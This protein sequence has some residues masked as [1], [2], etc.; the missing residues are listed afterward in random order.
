MFGLASVAIAPLAS[1]QTTQNSSGRRQ[2]KACVLVSGNKTAGLSPPIKRNFT[3]HLW[4]VMD[5]REDV[6]PGG[7]EFVNPLAPSTITGEIYKRWQTRGGVI[8]PA[9]RAMTPESFIFQIGAQ[10]TKNMAPYW[11][12]DLDTI[13][14]EDLRQ[15]DI[16][17][18]SLNRGITFGF[19]SEIRE[20]L[21]RF[22]DGGGT[23]WLESGDKTV[24]IDIN[25]PFIFPVDFNGGET[26]GF[27]PTIA[28]QRHPILQTPFSISQFEAAGIGARAGSHAAHRDGNDNKFLA[29]PH[30]LYP[31]LWSGRGGNATPYVSAGDY[32]AG[33]VV[34]SSAGIAIGVTSGVGAGVTGVE[35]YNTNVLSGSSLNGSAPADLKI[36]YNIVSFGSNASTA[37]SNAR[38]T[39]ATPDKVGG[40]LGTKWATV[41]I[42]ANEAGGTGAVVSKGIAYYVQTVDGKYTLRAYDMNPSTDLDRDGD[43]DD[44]IP[45][46]RLGAPYDEIW[47]ANLPEG[48]YSTPTV[49]TYFDVGF[50]RTRD[51]VSVTRFDGRTFRFDGLPINTATQRILPSGLPSD[52]SP[53]DAGGF[54]DMITDLGSVANLTQLPAPAFSEGFLFTIGYSKAGT[55]DAENWR[56]YAI[57]SLTGKNAFETNNAVLPPII[58][59]AGIP[60]ANNG[61]PVP[62]GSISVGYV[63]DEASGALDKIAYVAT[64]PKPSDNSP[65][66]QRE[67][68]IYGAWFATKGEPLETTDSARRVWSPSLSRRRFPWYSGNNNPRLAPRLYSVTRNTNGDV[69]ETQ[70]FGPANFTL[71]YS[72]RYMVITLNAGVILPPGAELFADYTLDWSGEDPAGTLGPIKPTAT[73][74]GALVR[75]SMKMQTAPIPGNFPLS[76]PTGAPALSGVDTL[77]FANNITDPLNPLLVSAPARIYSVHD[78][79]IVTE[80]GQPRRTSAAGVVRQGGVQV[81]W[82]FAPYSVQEMPPFPGVSVKSRLT[83]ETSD[84]VTTSNSAPLQKFR[85]IGSPAVANGVAYVTGTAESGNGTQTVI[86]AL[87]ANPNMTF[88]LGQ[89]YDVNARFSIRQPDL[90]AVP[91][92][93]PAY[94]A[95]NES[96]GNFI[97]DRNSGLVTITN[98]K[99]G[100]VS[101]TNGTLNALNLALPFELVTTIPTAGNTTTYTPLVNPLT[102]LGRLDNLLWYIT[103]PQRAITAGTPIKNRVNDFNNELLDD[104]PSFTGVGGLYGVPASGPS[105]AGEVLYFGTEDG[106][107]ASIDLNAMPSSGGSASLFRGERLRLKYTRVLEDSTTGGIIAQPIFYPPQANASSLVIGTPRGLAAL[108]SRLTII[109]DSGRLIEVDYGVDAITTISG[110]RST[111]SSFGETQPVVTNKISISRPSVARRA[112]FNDFVIA[113]T[114]NNR[115]VRTD[116][117]G[118]TTWELTK[119]NDGFRVA[120][121]AESLL[122]PTDVQ[123]SED[124]TGNPAAQFRVRNPL[125]GVIYASAAGAYYAV[126]YLIADSGNYRLI[127][128]VDAYDIDGNP[129][130]VVNPNDATDTVIMYHQAVWSTRTLSDQNKRLHFR[131]VQEF[132]NPTLTVAGERDPLYL[133][134]S[135]DNVNTAVADVGGVAFGANGSESSSVGGSLVAFRRYRTDETPVS[136]S[137]DGDLAVVINSIVYGNAETGVVT[138]RQSLNQPT[139]FR[140]FTTRVGNAVQSRYLM[141]DLTGAYVLRPVGS[142]AFVEWAL[143]S[144]DYYRMTGR[145]LRAA[146]LQKLPQS[147]YDP[148]TNRFYPRYLVTNQFS[149]LDNLNQ[150]F[151]SVLGGNLA[152]RNL[153]RDSEMRGEVFE[154]R[155]KDYFLAG[156]YRTAASALYNLGATTPLVMNSK[157]AIRWMC[158]KETFAFSSTGLSATQR[159]ER[160]IGS[161][162]ASTFTFNLE[163]PAFSERQN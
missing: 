77:I 109:A 65:Q 2:I 87:R 126:R 9:F 144:E 48:R 36:A 59:A 102:G 112:R 113:D 33:H 6:K 142:E 124:G 146:S 85:A 46:F 99:P 4:Y 23:L 94:I 5:K 81:P 19:D 140:Q 17:I 103:I 101:N 44:G 118:L 74:L 70:V 25:A 27:R 90:L 56:I 150:Y 21:R 120:S 53:N 156:G 26:S 24:R 116:Q 60:K 151:T 76:V 133:I 105:I 155:S 111:N 40:Q 161:E 39:G 108:D 50:G 122:A 63:K 31:V 127:E 30:E 72:L 145:P 49:V 98:L 45:D 162:D 67:G 95:I 147:D 121:G 61:I 88:S 51:M 42:G 28:A 34:V 139:F 86:L 106:R 159:I 12:V 134:A 107:I 71:S 149:G 15:F 11:E 3:P 68:N 154:I 157:S 73:E 129:L 158:P 91:N 89:S 78:Q 114:G 38:R 93:T 100:N 75:R 55:N 141:C 163:Q 13:T 137:R 16:A 130:V 14:D 7:W 41:P 136:P 47:E 104:D 79:V 37:S 128:V 22:V 80:Q 20:R 97:V 54:G 43:S 153:L 8:D 1:A 119:L 29:A 160:K 62:L 148:G 143:T 92:G 110:T 10:V 35:G 96:E 152:N 58:P 32:G 131:T 52:N 135:V 66:E 117:S 57:D 83:S 69:T 18:I 64:G 125:T 115:V 132:S 84:F 138:R 82:M 123:V